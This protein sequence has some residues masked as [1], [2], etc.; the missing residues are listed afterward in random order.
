MVVFS[1]SIATVAF[2]FESR[3]ESET[4]PKALMVETEGLTPND[5]DLY[6]A[7]RAQL[8]ASPLMLG[9]V[10]IERAEGV[11]FDPQGV[12]SRLSAENGAAMVFWIRD[13]A[14]TSTMFFYLSGASDSAIHTRV[15]QPVS[16][17]RSSRFEVIAN[18][19]ASVIEECL[20]SSR[21][22]LAPPVQPTVIKPP[23]ISAERNQKRKWVELF[24]SY[25][26]SL[27][28]KGT[29]THGLN[30]GIGFFPIEHL[31]LSTSYTMNLPVKWE[32]EQYRLALTLRNIEASIAFRIIK[33]PVDF[34]LGLAWFVDLRSWSTVPFSEAVD[35]HPGELRAVYSLMPFASV[36]WMI[37][38]KIGIITGLG[39]N[40]AIEEKVYT[41]SYDN[42]SEIQV[43]RPFIAKFTYQ[44]GLVVQL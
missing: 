34:H 39:A 29:V 5:P 6:N 38:N 15:L 12:V 21:P 10:H 28:A 13:E 32:T 3:A 19:A 7:I 36:T 22:R 35:A 8:S 18:A 24:A 20:L 9:R 43:A 41:V 23:P 33:G 26:G 4:F 25:L 40:L 14:A 16:G 27:F 30:M 11:E 44:L 17:S 37:L 42:G 2:C 1:L 31:A